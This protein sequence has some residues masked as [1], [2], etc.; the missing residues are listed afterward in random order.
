MKKVVAWIHAN[1]VTITGFLA[2][3]LYVLDQIFKFTKNFQITQEIYYG[4]AALIVFLIG[5]A[6]QG[7]GFES[8]EE[9]KKITKNHKK[10]KESKKLKGK[11]TF[12]VDMVNNKDKNNTS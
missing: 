7:R 8:I 11:V 9:F 1:K 3:L 6:I 10:L 2:L 12:I 5:Y 4:V